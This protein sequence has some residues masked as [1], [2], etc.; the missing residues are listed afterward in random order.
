MAFRLSGKRAFSLCYVEDLIRGVTLAA[1]RGRDQE[2]YY[3][4]EKSPRSWEEISQAIA[5]ALGVRPMTVP[6]PSALLAGA[7]WAWEG[8]ARLAGVPP[9]PPPPPSLAPLGRGGGS[10]AWRESR[11]CSTETRPVRCGSGT[12]SATRAR[13]HTNWVS[14]P[15]FPW[16]WERNGRPSGIRGTA[17]CKG[18][19]WTSSTNVTHTPTPSR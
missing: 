4:G 14:P 8:I 11:P 3:L 9:L 12:G 5:A 16:T 13:P 19:P 15:P 18:G 17:G 6:V 1:E 2:I 10:P 7:A